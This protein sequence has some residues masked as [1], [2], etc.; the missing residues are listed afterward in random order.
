MGNIKAKMTKN[1]KISL[2][3]EAGAL[4]NDEIYFFSSEYNLLYKVHMPDF[5]VSI[6]S[7]IPCTKVVAYRW[8]RKMCYWNEKLIFI[9]SLAERV[10]IYDLNSGGWENIIIDFPQMSLKFWGVTLY[11]NNIFLFGAAYPAILKINLNDYSTS[12]LEIDCPLGKKEEGLHFTDV[13]RVNNIAFSSVSTSNHVIRL[14]LDTFEYEWKQIGS[15][16]N[17]YCGIARDGDEFWI[18][19]WRYGK[20]VKWDGDSYWEEFGVPDE[21]GKRTYQ[22]I[23]VVCD[24]NRIRFLTM[25]DGKSMEILKN[26]SG[27]IQILVTEETK[28][29]VHLEHYENGTIVLMRYDSSMDVRW[30]GIWLKGKCEIDYQVFKEYF[31]GSLIWDILSEKGVGREMKIFKMNDYVNIIKNQQKDN[32][33]CLDENMGM[34]IWNALQ[35]NKVNDKWNI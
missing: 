27:E 6:V 19:I 12:Y 17:E 20:I 24:E 14:N 9:P 29:Y 8:F 26:A 21:I 23:G 35:S 4:V 2:Y 32:S 22:F 25:Q 16:D 18:P 13:V 1:R 31:G 28:R 34:N 7:R 30:G 15:I 5:V 10:W 11:Q 33:V 3:A